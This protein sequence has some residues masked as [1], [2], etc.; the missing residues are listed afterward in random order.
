MQ[1]GSSF[2]LATQAS[3][4]TP[5]SGSIGHQR[6]RKLDEEDPAPGYF[7]LLLPSAVFPDG[8]FLGWTPGQNAPLLPKD[9]AWRLSRGT[10]LVVEIHFVPNGKTETVKPTV[11]LYLTDDP[12]TRTPAM[13]RLGRQDIEIPAGQKDYVSTDTFVL[14]VD[15]E[16]LAVQPHAHYRAREVRGTATRPDGTTTPLIYIKDWDYR[17]QH[18]YRYVR[19]AGVA[20]G[21]DAVDAVCLRQL[22]G[23]SPQPAPAAAAGAL[24]AAVHRRNGRPV[25]PDADAAPTRT[26]RHSTTCCA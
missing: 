24:G 18:V 17:W 1:E 14:P 11:G 26:C 16:V 3:C 10:D 6:S 19:A 9:L 21:H 5:T 15:V 25:G 8:H 4:I 12:P 2:D 22:G 7:G 20:Q 13:L 23:E